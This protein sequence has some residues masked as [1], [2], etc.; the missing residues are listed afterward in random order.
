MRVSSLDP[1]G[2]AIDDNAF[3][4]AAVLQV[5]YIPVSLLL[6]ARGGCCVSAFGVNAGRLKSPASN[7]I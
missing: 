5:Y 4:H 2:A 3:Y 6:L 1:G 7:K